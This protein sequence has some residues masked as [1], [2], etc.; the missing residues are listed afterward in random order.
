LYIQKILIV[1]FGKLFKNIMYKS[2]LQ[3]SKLSRVSVI[4]VKKF[5]EFYINNIKIYIV[6]TYIT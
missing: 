5:L 1:N 6:L 4:Y 2:Q 3:I